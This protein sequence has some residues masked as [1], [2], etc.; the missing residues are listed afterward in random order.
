[1]KARVVSKRADSHEKE[2]D[3]M[4]PAPKKAAGKGDVASSTGAFDDARAI[5]SLSSG[6]IFRMVDLHVHTPASPDV[7]AK[8]KDAKPSDVVEHALKKGIDV[9]AVTDHNSADWCDSV[10]EAAKGTQLAVFP[11]VEISTSEGHLLGIFDPKT[12][13]Q[14]IKELLIR[15]GISQ[16]D[17]GRPEVLASG[18]ID[19]IAK[20]VEEAGGL[21]IAAHV[22]Q[23]KGFWRMTEGSRTRRNQI[24]ASPNIVA[25]EVVTAEALEQ[26]RTLDVGDARRLPCIQGSDCWPENSDSHHVDGIGGRYCLIKMDDLSVD[27]LRQAL[28]DPALHVCLASQTRVEPSAVIE[29]VS[30]TGGFLDGQRFR[31]NDNISCLIG[32]TGAGKSLT[33]ELIRFALDQQTPAAVLPNIADDVNLLLGFAMGDAANVRVLVRKSGERYLVERAWQAGEASDPVVYRLGEN[34]VELV[35]GPVHLPSFLPIKGFSQGEVIEHAREPLAR[36]SLI[37]DLIDTDTERSAIK[38]FKSQLR[39]NAKSIIETRKKIENATT[40]VKEL[41][42]IQEQIKALSRFFEDPKVKG[43]A[44]WYKEKDAFQNASDQVAELLGAIDEEFP[45]PDS[46]W[47][48]PAATPNTEAMGKLRR[49]EEDIAK[50]KEKHKSAYHKD[51]TDL[52]KQIQDLHSTWK[53]LFESAE[54]EYQRLLTE[55]DTDGK[56]LASLSQKLNRL[57]E[58]ETQ[59]L[60]TAKQMDEKLSPQ[61]KTLEHEREG[62]LDKLQTARRAIRGKRTSKAKELTD[63]LDGRV[64]ISVRGDADDR[65]FIEALSAIRVGSHIQDGEV[66]A[67]AKRLHPVPFVK[68]L[69]TQDFD[70]PA[71]E[72]DLAQG[73]FQRLHETIHERNRLGDLYELQLVDLEDGV[74]IQFAVEE[75]EYRDLEA[76]AHGQKCTVVLMVALAQGDAPLIVDQPEDALH[77]PW[78]EEYIVARLRGDRGARQCLFATRSGNVL[79]SADAEQVLAMDADAHAGRVTKTGALDRFET[80]EL[81]LYHVEGGREAF[82]RRKLKYGF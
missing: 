22:D 25:L 47:T 11:G 8:W 50:A 70:T 24:Y 57:R 41:P 68:S 27:A 49:V 7:N 33:L 54:H 69:L 55:L 6:A 4:T 82:E 65:A 58:K 17:F 46:D 18:R 28:L 14:T 63:R 51:V 75:Q 23:P 19:E 77:A 9:I 62:L 78:I 13:A 29:G 31:F 61:V 60:R 40:Q 5:L 38:N 79:V 15:C 2:E 26:F 1:M 3:P 30:V 56:G 72:S 73:V 74:R 44:G 20:K 36:L 37:D 71:Q 10:R 45:H 76:L 32:G 12:A 21:A 53:P 66:K 59:L 16:A 80:R 64:R 35:D 34:D 67:M 43:H 52:M 48:I 81:V 42:G 39:E